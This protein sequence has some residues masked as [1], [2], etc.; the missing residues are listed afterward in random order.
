MVY[1]NFKFNNF[2][3]NLIR[4][5]APSAFSI[6]LLNTHRLVWKYLLENLFINISNLS[7]LKIFTYIMFFSI[8]F[9]VITILIDKIRIILF[10]LFHVDAL[11]KK[12][13]NL[14]Y[15]ILN[16]IIKCIK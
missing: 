9:V 6:Y 10:K 5:S 1:G 3:K 14:L 2:V 4:F 7:V 15:N 16:K 8:L 12:I 11:A 13:N